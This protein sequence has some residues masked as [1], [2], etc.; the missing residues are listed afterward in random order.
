MLSWPSIDVPDTATR[1]G[2]HNGDAGRVGDSPHGSEVGEGVAER[3]TRMHT[4]CRETMGQNTG[5]R[6]SEIPSCFKSTSRLRAGATAL[7]G[8]ILRRR[9]IRAWRG[10][11]PAKKPRGKTIRGGR[12]LPTESGSD[13]AKDHHRYIYIY[14]SELECKDR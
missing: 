6:F 2:P 14:H 3:T 1:A 10:D 11:A 8:W 4:L 13:K 7:S 12:D 9:A 5:Q